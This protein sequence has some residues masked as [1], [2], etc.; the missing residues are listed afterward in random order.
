MQ[1]NKIIGI[2]DIIPCFE[3]AL[4]K[5]IELIHV[6]VHEELTRQIAK[7]KSN[8]IHAIHV[9]TADY[10]PEQPKH[11][12]ICD[13]SSEDI[14]QNLMIDIGKE[15]PEATQGK[16]SHQIMCPSGNMHVETPTLSGTQTRQ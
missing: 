16:L 4:R 13:P 12:F 5:L 11:I 1:E 8:A 7:R 2:P 6:Y 15:C 9:K 14:H 3:L 10:L